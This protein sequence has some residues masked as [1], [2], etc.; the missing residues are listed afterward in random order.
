MLDFVL[1]SSEVDVGLTY[2]LDY[3]YIGFFFTKDMVDCVIS[4]S[5]ADLGLPHS[6]Q[7]LS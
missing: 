2:S 6:W 7:Y 4:S 1:A 3:L 5:E